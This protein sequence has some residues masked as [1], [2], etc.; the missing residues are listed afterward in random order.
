MGIFFRLLLFQVGHKTN[1][2]KQNKQI[3]MKLILSSLLFSPALCAPGKDAVRLDAFFSS[4][5][6]QRIPNTCSTRSGQACVF[7]FKYKGVEYLK[8]TFADS[9]T[10]WCATQTDSSENVVT[11]K[12]GDCDDSATTSCAVENI[13]VASCSTSQGQ[14]VFPFRYKGIVYNGCTSVDRGLSWCS[15]NTDVAGEHIEGNEGFCPLSCPLHSGSSSSCTPGSSF[16]VDCNTCVCDTNGVSVCSTNTCTTSSTTSSTITSTTSTTTT[17]TTT[18][19]ESSSSS[20]SCLT[21]NGPDTGSACIF[22]FTFNG[23]TYVSC[24]EWV[25]GGEFQGQKWCSTKV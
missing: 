13:N 7:P 24:A 16:T 8:C 6:E 10:P 20:S 15:T 2:K 22:P 11:N 12:W 9:P 18:T 17:T 25:Y 5:L 19:T 23:V 4:D 1:K 3:V 21:V 14:C